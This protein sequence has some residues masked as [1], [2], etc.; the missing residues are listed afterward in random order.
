MLQHSKWHIGTPLVALVLFLMLPVGLVVREGIWQGGPTWIYLSQVLKEP[1][2]LKIFLNTMRLAGITALFCSLLAYPLAFQ[3]NSLSGVGRRILLS[4]VV[5][6]L[7]INPLAFLYA[8]VVILQKKGL[9]SFLLLRLFRLPAGEVSLLY[10][11]PGVIVV[12]VYLL[13]PYSILLT[14]AGLAQVD[15]RNV[16]VARNLGANSWA[17]FRRVV[18]PITFPSFAAGALVVFALGIGY[19]ITPALIGGLGE[20]TVSMVIADRMQEPGSW[21]IAGALTVLLLV[22]LV[23]VFLLMLRIM[24]PQR[25]LIHLLQ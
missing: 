9:L 3:V 12:M 5:T 13:L 4:V 19:F 17:A 21:R 11:S 14:M 24:R 20:T 25:L 6:P 2:Y 16:L 18:F 10:S 8:W 22:T 7:V 15:P 23:I 1:A